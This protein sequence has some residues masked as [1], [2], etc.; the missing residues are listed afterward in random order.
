MSMIWVR[1][2]VQVTPLNHYGICGLWKA[3]QGLPLMCMIVG[4]YISTIELMN[5]LAPVNRINFFSV[6]FNG[7]DI[8]FRR[9]H[10]FLFS[11]LLDQLNKAERKMIQPAW[12]HRTFKI[13]S[14]LLNDS[15][16]MTVCSY[17]YTTGLP[18]YPFLTLP[19]CFSFQ[20]CI[21]I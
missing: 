8:N 7:V 16:N 3:E 20:K 15:E 12:S 21:F 6:G 5:R 11:F 2:W 13:D 19:F 14:F 17:E 4:C 9:K 10:C 18:C 1:S